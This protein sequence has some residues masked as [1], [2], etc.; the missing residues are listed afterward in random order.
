VVLADTAGATLNLNDFSNTIGSLSGGGVSGGNV[1]LGNATLTIGGD[2]TSP[3]AYFGVISGTGAVVKAGT[4][5]LTLSGANTYSGATTIEAGKIIAGNSRALGTGAGGVA[6]NATLDIGSTTLNIDGSYTQGAGA[7]LMVAVN[8]ASSGSIAAAGVATFNTNDKLILAVSNYVPHNQ[9][10]TIIG[11]ADTSVYGVPDISITGGNRAT[12]TFATVGNNLILTAS[13]AANG[14]ASDANNPNAAA[15]GSVLDTITNPSADMTT[16]LNTLSGLSNAQVASALD[17][18]IPTVDYSIPQTGFDSLHLCLNTIVDHL[19]VSPSPGT[20]IS[21]GDSL[22]GVGIWVQGFGSY[23]HEAPRGLS[24]GYNATIW[25]T[26]IGFDVPTIDNLKFGLAAGFANDNIRGKDNSTRTNVDNYQGSVYSSYAEDAYYVNSAFTFAYNQYNSSRR[27]AFAT[28]DR[29][30]K[31]DYDGQAYSVYVEG[32][33]GFKNKKTTLT[34]LASVQYARLHVNGYTETDADALNLNVNS[35]NYDLAQT[36]LGFKLDHAFYGRYGTLIPELRIKWLYDWVGDNQQDVSTFTG[37][38]ASFNTVGL[39]P[40]QSYYDFGAKITLITK[41]N[42]TL[43]VNYDLGLKE[44]FY[45]HNGY[46][47][48]RYDF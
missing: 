28:I 41:N 22:K 31:A 20:G 4:G 23:L 19:S 38:G 25:G 3:S 48:V 11:G 2:N 44:D 9:T 26:L 34:P 15:A 37:G 10:Y 14:F 27:S 45:S 46:V 32:G 5:T 30:A 16:V 13:R 21:S 43:S 47:N 12:F 42:V 36:G 6:N 17:A 40:A 24:N 7:T 18:I 39:T 35:Q 33:Y 1:T 29:T 8:G